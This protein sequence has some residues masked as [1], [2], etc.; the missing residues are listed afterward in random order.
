MS[1][2]VATAAPRFSPGRRIAVVWLVAAVMAGLLLCYGNQLPFG[3]TGFWII[4]K[5]RLVTVGTILVVACAQA[6]ATVVFHTITGKRILTP[7]IMGFDALY[8][9][10]QTSLVFFLG[11]AA[12]AETDGL[13]KVVVQSV[14][15]VAFATLLYGFLLGRKGNLHIMLLIG[16]VLGTGLTALSTFMQRMLTPSEFDLLTA[17][18]LGSLANS[19]AEYLPWAVMVC[20]LV[21]VVLWVRSSRLDVV[22]LGRDTAVNLGIRYQREVIGNLI[23]VAVL[24]SVSASLVGPMTF[25]GFLVALLTYQVAGTYQHR[26]VLPLAAGLGAATLFTAYFVLRHVFYA[27]GAITVIIEFAG[28][29]L[30]LIMLLRK[31]LR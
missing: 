28:G 12:L 7:S 24:I 8:R 26:Y 13:A 10:L 4:V 31:G 18:L 15:M 22:A 19:N 29:L 20:G 3:S 14:L 17:R 11:G 23:L 1:E 27:A 25:F 9:V 21:T 16:V 30:F 2:V 5:S 6:V